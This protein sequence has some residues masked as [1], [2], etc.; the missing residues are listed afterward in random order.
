MDNNSYLHG[1]LRLSDIPKNAIQTLEDGTKAI[2]VDVKERRQPSETGQTHYIAM[3]IKN[4]QGVYENVYIGNLKEEFFGGSAPAQPQKSAGRTPLYQ[5][6]AQ[7]KQQGQYQAPQPD[8]EDDL[9][10]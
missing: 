10:F 4:S 2:Y 6:A 3:R 5:Q 1:M 9:G 8:P 7:M